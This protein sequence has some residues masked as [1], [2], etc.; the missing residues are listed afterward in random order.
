MECLVVAIQL[1][2]KVGHI[3]AVLNVRQTTGNR[4]NDV[5]IW[6]LNRLVTPIVT[7]ILTPVHFTKLKPQIVTYCALNQMIMLVKVNIKST[8]KIILLAMLVL[9]KFHCGRNVG[10]TGMVT[11][12][13]CILGGTILLAQKLVPLLVGGLIY[14]K[15]MVQTWLQIV[16]LKSGAKFLGHLILASK[17]LENLNCML[18][19]QWKHQLG[20]WK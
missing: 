15:R 18:V 5:A 9:L 19:I 11:N 1:N 12:N 17:K 10:A 3:M 2:M 13:C 8:V 16:T 20:I 6:K 4:T 7:R 14:K